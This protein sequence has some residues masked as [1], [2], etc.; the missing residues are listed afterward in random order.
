MKKSFGIIG[1]HATKIG[2]IIALLLISSMINY[3]LDLSQD[4]AYSLSKISKT[5]VRNLEDVMVVKIISSQELPADLNSLSRYTND[6]LSEYQSAGRGKFRYEYLRPASRDELYQLAQANAL[7]PMRFQIFENDQMTSKEV[8]F[9][10]VFE[11][12]GRVESM[13][14]MPRLEP[15]L[16][17][18]MTMRI[19]SLVSENLPKV[20]VF[21]DSTYYHFNTRFFERG[22]RSNFKVSDAD[23]SQ[24][25]SDIDALLFTGASRNLPEEYLYHLDQYL[26]Q[27]GN[28]V[29]L[30]DRVDTDGSMLYSLDTNVIRMLEHYGFTLSRDVLLDMNNDQR[31]MGIGNMA[32]FPMYPIMRGGQHPISKNMDYI[33]LYLA[34]GITI[35]QKD[36]LKYETIL[37]S[38]PYSGWMRYPDF[39]I[40]ENLFFNPE[41]EDFTAGPIITAAMATGSF[42]SY[43]AG[44]EL[45]A[46]DPQFRAS[47]ET[48]NLLLFADKE[49]VIDPD[50][51]LYNDRSNVILNALDYFSGRPDMIRIRNRH[52]SSSILSVQAFMEKYGLIWA[53]VQKTDHHIK[54][55][56]KI[57]AIALP[58]LILILVGAWMAFRRKLKIKAINEAK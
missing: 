50:N 10:M 38:S 32:N 28:V 5:L 17:Y 36:G 21:R 4:K 12:Q 55:I 51:P 27:G 14:L 29:F 47:A 22:I 58:S 15:K 24:P 1:T 19:Q 52:L 46:S 9:G 33:V 11:Y 48:A 30:Q 37:Q 23:L 18:E 49:L 20:A 34:S 45:A 42:T 3:R 25:L 57:T 35:A 2:I 54:L 56:T 31:Q 7:R 39:N 40:G 43:F 41:L 6:L 16:E 44:T 8:I 13:N 26:M 53:D